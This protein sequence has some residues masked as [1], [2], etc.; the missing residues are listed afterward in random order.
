MGQFRIRTEVGEPVWSA[1]IVRSDG[2]GVVSDMDGIAVVPDNDM[3]GNWRITHVSHPA[4]NVTIDTPGVYTITL[5]QAIN[6]P[7]VV[8][9]FPEEPPP[10]QPPPAS[11][12]PPPPAPDKP[13]PTN[14]YLWILAGLATIA[15][16]SNRR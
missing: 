9:I 4:I 8:E 14:N 5:A 3:V 15:F 12:P 13:D 2:M 6:L 1:H 10:T 16:L 7:P 11:P